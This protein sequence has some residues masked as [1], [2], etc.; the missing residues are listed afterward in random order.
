VTRD[1][2]G[3]H[4]GDR[5]AATREAVAR[6]GRALGAG[7]WTAWPEAERQAF[8]R[9]A[10]VTTLVPDL[11][12]WPQEDRARLV[13]LIRAKGGRG[14]GPYVRQLLAHARLGRSLR[15]LTARSRAEG[16]APS[17]P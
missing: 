13:R 4:H 14:E 11:E 16:A 5:E 7:R 9:W 2:A 17:R 8:R 10:L 12:R 15:A 1:I 3:R 6:V